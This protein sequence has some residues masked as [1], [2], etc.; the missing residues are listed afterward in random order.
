MISFEVVT[1]MNFMTIT[2]LLF[3]IGYSV[4]KIS[5]RIGVKG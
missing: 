3:W 5:E 2:V 4:W 1:T